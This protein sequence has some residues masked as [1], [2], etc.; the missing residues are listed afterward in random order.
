MTAGQPT[1]RWTALK[2]RA[3]VGANKHTEAAPHLSDR[4]RRRLSV[5][6]ICREP[7]F[8][9]LGGS[10][11]YLAALFQGLDAN[12]IGMRV[13]VT[14]G[15]RDSKRPFFVLQSGIPRGVEYIAPGY[16]RI[17]RLYLRTN[18][19]RGWLDAGVEFLD[20]AIGSR[21]GLVETFAERRRKRR[22]DAFRAWDTGLADAAETAYI[23]RVE[24]ASDGAAVGVN[25]AFLCQG[26]GGSED[27]SKKRF[28]IMHD[29]LSRR[30]AQIQRI[31]E[32][33]DASPITFEQEIAL[34]QRADLVVAIQP[35][36]AALL[37]AVTHGKTILSI[38]HMAAP[39]RSRTAQ[40]AGRVLFVGTQILPNLDGMR[41]FL[42]TVWPTV[43]AR[44]PHAQVHVCGT[45]CRPLRSEFPDVPGVVFRGVVPDLTEEYG[46]AEACIV[47]LRVG[48]GMKIKLV[49]A[50]AHGRA[51]V[52]TET[53]V[54]GI[55]KLV[56]DAVTVAPIGD[57]FA[58]E[59]V[60]ILEDADRRRRME[61]AGLQVVAEHFSV[62]Q[63]IRPLAEWISG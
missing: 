27:C 44:L 32:A 3:S 10:T 46:A 38:P 5:D 15:L 41:L 63:R 34:L 56:E 17:G 43:V 54:L 60:A 36:E 50:L 28:V 24:R 11:S 30:Q 49:E 2:F 7:P 61:Q 47:P 42:T 51:C 58:A 48:T 16:L 39:V 14:A 21:L 57:A 8:S 45:A 20:R 4:P 55:R 13:H 25:Y 37:E 22:P 59:L 19:L 12:G 62:E 18:S 9:G 31:G 52:A 26:F 29:L 40:K 23:A 33:L 35:D 1:L 6:L 53:G